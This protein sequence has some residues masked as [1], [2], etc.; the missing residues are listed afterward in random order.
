MS[1]PSRRVEFSDAFWFQEGPGVLRAQFRDSGVKLLNVANITK[2]GQ[3]NL[4]KT[5]R[6]IEELEAY[7]KYKHFL[8]DEG[9]L[10]IASSGISIDNDGLLRTRGSFIKKHHLPL[11]MNTS[12]IRFKAIEGK[13]DL[14]YLRHWLQSHDFRVQITR[15]VTGIAQKNFGPTH[16]K[17]LSINLPP[18]EEQKRI[19]AILDQAD[20][21]R[22]LRQRS[23][24][25]LNSLGQAIF[26]EM[27]GDSDNIPTEPLGEH[28]TKIGSGATP[29]GGDAA[30]KK[31][32]I[33]LVRSMNIRDGYFDPKGLA[34]IDDEQA[35][36]LDNV[37]L[38]ENDVLLNITG[39]SVARVCLAPASVNT[40]R[41][42]Q[43]V[44]IIRLKE[45]IEP[46]YLE[47]FLLFPRTKQKLLTIAE[48][49]ATRQAITKTQMEAFYVPVPPIE[50]Q[51]L[52]VKK[53]LE[54]IQNQ[55]LFNQQIYEFEK[56]FLSLQHKAFNG[57]L[58]E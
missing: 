50:Q 29:K 30:Y 25:R 33:P 18:L 2:D 35:N 47:A 12:T 39:A 32:G 54:I 31:I 48:A 56:L 19:A 49:G 27:F 28:T 44:S 53:R 15:L 11:C 13:S 16:L 4:E 36:K 52:F 14:S 23:I 7:G 57:E 20:A 46:S 3:I 5:E 22:R 21:L 26:Y 41:V 40:G 43:H 51:R 58:S 55:D 24:D 8:I 42:N 6:H 9:D 37:T 38:Q 1:K 45:T 17:A 34:Y 10:V